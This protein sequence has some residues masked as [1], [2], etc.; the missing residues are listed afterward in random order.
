M[1]IPIP[2]VKQISMKQKLRLAGLICKLERWNKPG[3]P[4]VAAIAQDVRLQPR[5]LIY[6]FIFRFVIFFPPLFSFFLFL[7]C[8]FFPLVRLLTFPPL[9]TGTIHHTTLVGFSTIHYYVGFS[10]IH[11]MLIFLPFILYC[12]NYVGYYNYIGF[13]TLHTILL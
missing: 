5:F 3:G 9:P 4:S 7:F 13:S 11:T 1:T 2:Q 12:Y 6:L 10:A 8:P